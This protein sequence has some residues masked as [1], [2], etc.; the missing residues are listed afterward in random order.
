MQST[1]IIL[2]DD[3]ALVRQGVRTL[4]EE[5]PGFHVV[6]EAET[7]D[8]AIPLAIREQPDVMLVDVHMPRGVDGV[9][10]AR[11]IKEAVPHT[12]IFMLTMFD[13]EVHL[14][15]MLLAG[16]DG[17][18]FKHDSSQEIISA[19]RSTSSSKGTPYLPPRIRPEI[20]QKLLDL[21]KAPSKSLSSS[22][23][24]PRETEILAL[25]AQGYTNREI[26]DR[27]H[28][29]VKTVEAHRARIVE[30]IGAESRVDLIQYALQHGLISKPIL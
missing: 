25:I 7:G 17:V 10:A 20:R 3:H 5:E 12:R 13:D 11:R 19:I 21:L 15:R 23:L 18:L 16:V 22:V 4:L 27:L 26:A 14:E 6:G 24:T 30:R 9:T 28:I 29:S 2:V 1:R 8:D